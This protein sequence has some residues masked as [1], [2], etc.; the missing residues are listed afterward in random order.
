MRAYSD[1]SAV[2]L[3][4]GDYWIARRKETPYLYVCWYD[5]RTQKVTRKS[6]A[7][8]DLGAA[9]R[10][11]TALI[12]ANPD[13]LAPAEPTLQ[14]VLMW[15]WAD[16]ACN[17]SYPSTGRS[18]LRYWTNHFG[19]DIC[20]SGLRP[21]E[22]ETFWD[23][24]RC[25]GLQES[26]IARITNIGRAAIYRA[27]E[28]QLLKV[29]PK[30]KSNLTRDDLLGAPP[31]GRPLLKEE[32]I[33]LFRTDMPD[34]LL[35]FALIMANTLC[36]TRAALEL[37]REQVEFD[38]RLVHLNPKGRIQ[39]KKRRPT[40]RLTKTLAKALT[41]R[42]K[43]RL[44]TRADEPVSNIYRAWRT[45]VRKADLNEPDRVTPYSLRH[46]LARHLRSQRIP[47]D[48]IELFLGHRYPGDAS[49]MTV[50]YAPYDPDYLTP[51]ANCIDRLF[52]EIR[53]A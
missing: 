35:V 16:Y 4:E 39:T 53:I 5:R 30:I 1:T 24:L 40:V 21:R 33:A 18:A 12:L 42:P 19:P 45:L 7:E 25:E 23:H 20:P 26:T 6:T 47:G 31:M 38:H 29:R 28:F 51:A 11:L 36:R 2:L 15:Y 34:Y 9:S 43:G 17:L 49:P 46:T 32:L 13:A 8:T 41:R 37:T 44:V 50:R 3:R 48:Q 22:I 14:R 10:L 52:A 27:H